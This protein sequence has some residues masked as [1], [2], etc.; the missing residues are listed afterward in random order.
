MPDNAVTVPRNFQERVT[1]KI[2]ESIA[3]LIDDKDIKNLVEVSIKE[4]FFTEKQVKK[5]G[6]NSWNTEYETLPP[7]MH[8]IIK[9]MLT[10]SI[11][12]QVK[13]ISEQWIVE[14]EEWMRATIT[15][16]MEVN[17]GQAFIKAFDGLFSVALGYT[18]VQMQSVMTN[19]VKSAMENPSAYNI[20]PGQYSPPG[21]R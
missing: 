7:L 18:A 13:A 17:A 16:T 12:A 4:V 14:N 5:Q 6:M 8:S 21:Y 10:E 11:K 2:R 9:E 19:T 15:K 20:H 1:E 3:D